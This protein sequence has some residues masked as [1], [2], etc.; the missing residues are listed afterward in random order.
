MEK[1]GILAVGRGSEHEPAFVE[2]TYKGDDSKP[3]VALVGKGVTFD[4]GGISLKSGRNLSDM[5]MDMG[6]AAAVAGALQL[7]AQSK[8]KVNVVGLIQ[9][10]E[11]MSD[12]NS[13]LPGDVITYKNGKTVQVGNT[14]AE[15]RLI[16]ADGRSRAEELAAD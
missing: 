16:L 14:D 4:T 10:V 12:Q 11:N 3:L 2:M 15:G 7:L 13:L 6:G 9:T 5:R 1:N 8:A